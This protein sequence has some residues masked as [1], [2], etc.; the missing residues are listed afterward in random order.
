MDPHLSHKFEESEEQL[1][2]DQTT[3]GT[4]AYLIIYNDDH[5]TFDWVIQCLMDVCNHTHEQSEQLSL[6][7]HFKGKAIVKTGPFDSLKPLKDAL[8]DRGLS[9]VIETE[10]ESR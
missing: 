1:V 8:L 3:E 9:A 5:N 10:V 6:I 4:V 7:I 2:L